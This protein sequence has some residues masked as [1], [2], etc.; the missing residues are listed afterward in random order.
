MSI[1]GLIGVFP[2][3]VTEA[4]VATFRDLKRSRN[5]VYAE[6]KVVSG[7]PK[8][9]R[10]DRV[11]DTVSLKIIVHPIIDDALSVDARVL[12]YVCLPRRGRNCHLF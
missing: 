11:L 2:F 5:I 3:T 10:T 9:E 8:I 6:H 12:P 1:Q 4:M 7:L